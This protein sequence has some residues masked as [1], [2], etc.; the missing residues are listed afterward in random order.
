MIIPV[1]PFVSWNTSCTSRYHGS[2]S[3]MTPTRCFRASSCCVSGAFDSPVVQALVCVLFVSWFSLFLSAFL[4]WS[5]VLCAVESVCGCCGASGQEAFVFAPFFCVL[6]FWPA[7]RWLNSWQPMGQYWSARWLVLIQC[8]S[9]ALRDMMRHE[10]WTAAEGITAG[11]TA[12]LAVPGLWPFSQHTRHQHH[13]H[14]WHTLYRHHKSH[15]SHGV[16]A[17]GYGCGPNP[18]GGVDMPP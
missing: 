3:F 12:G 17:Y 18:I 4:W 1:P 15:Q 14:H 9:M 7:G 8:W 16:K 6:G 2:L 5:G 11:I 13:P 10:P